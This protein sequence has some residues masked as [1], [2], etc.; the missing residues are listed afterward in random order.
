M[1]RIVSLVLVVFVS[2]CQTAYKDGQPNE[3]SPNFVVPVDSKLILNQDLSVPART[4]IVYVQRGKILSKHFQVNRFGTFCELELSRKRDVPQTIEA[5]EFVIYRV[6]QERVF[7]DG[8]FIQLAS[9]LRFGGVVQFER[10]GDGFQLY[11]VVATR[12]ALRSE[13]QPDVQALVCAT[14]HVAQAMSYLTIRGIRNTLG[15]I[16]TLQLAQVPEAG[17]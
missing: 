9:R 13:R 14:W 16:F 7:G 8:G 11:E 17:L 5:D 2:A 4:D 10:D 1:I 6:K 12:M 3:G 15:D